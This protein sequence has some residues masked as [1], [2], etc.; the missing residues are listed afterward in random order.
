MFDGVGFRHL[1]DRFS[2]RLGSRTAVGPMPRDD[3]CRT[4][5]FS[6]FLHQFDLGVGVLSEVVNA[7][8]TGQTEY[9][10]NVFQVTFEV[11]A[12]RFKRGQVL[13]A[14]VRHRDTAVV[15]QRANRCDQHHHA[16]LQVGHTA[17]DVNEFL[18]AQI[19]SEARFGHHIV[20]EFQ[21]R[22]RRS[23]GIATM[24][25]VGKRT[26]MHER[27]IVLQTLHHVGTDGVFEQRRHRT[28]RLQFFGRD[29]FA[30]C[31]R[32]TNHDAPQTLF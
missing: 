31:A 12:P 5:R 25:D 13:L 29:R 27:D 28:V 2:K 23:H 6:F 15:F 4:Q 18:G 16:R 14:Q 17:F 7:H 21:R 24:R 30:F 19:G 22:T 1:R 9:L 8:D 10:G 26:A 32:V 3:C 20:G 11:N